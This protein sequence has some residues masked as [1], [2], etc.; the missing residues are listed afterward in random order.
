MLQ[1]PVCAL[2]A[3]GMP[4]TAHKIPKTRP[5]LARVDRARMTPS[6]WQRHP[7]SHEGWTR[8]NGRLTVI[9]GGCGGKLR[10]GGSSDGLVVPAVFHGI[11]VAHVNQGPSQDLAACGALVLAQ[12]ARARHADQRHENV[13]V[14]TC[15]L[16]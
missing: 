9:F 15:P 10:G 12:G 7:L 14:G 8:A 1:Q 11:K 4:T 3:P 6:V 2:T 13:P 16:R 5:S